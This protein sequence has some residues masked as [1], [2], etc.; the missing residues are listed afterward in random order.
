MVLLHFVQ[1]L[2]YFYFQFSR[3]SFDV[4]KYPLMSE[5]ISS[6]RMAKSSGSLYIYRGNGENLP[7]VIG[8]ELQNDLAAITEV[9]EA[10]TEPCIVGL[11]LQNKMQLGL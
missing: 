7:L 8:D 2:F 9:H 10:T 1:L 4:S 6:T 11:T 5:F 3:R